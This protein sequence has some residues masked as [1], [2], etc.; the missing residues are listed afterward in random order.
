M[1]NGEG[2]KLPSYIA[3]QPGKGPWSSGGTAGS[4]TRGRGG[5]NTITTKSCHKLQLYQFALSRWVSGIC[6]LSNLSAHAIRLIKT[7]M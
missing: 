1:P 7:N 2:K 4:V 3:E 5:Y 6:G